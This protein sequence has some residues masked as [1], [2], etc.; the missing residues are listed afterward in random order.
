M[1]NFPPK[2]YT[3]YPI[4]DPVMIPAKTAR[5]T[6]VAAVDIATPPTNIH[7]SNPSLNTTYSIYICVR[8]CVCVCVCVYNYCYYL[9]NHFFGA[10]FLFILFC[11]HA[12]LYSIHI[13][14]IPVM[15]QPKQ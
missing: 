5:G 2:K 10:L 8:V 6:A 1:S 7:A 9:Y 14:C 4:A 12:H 15:R 3:K 11:L 13:I